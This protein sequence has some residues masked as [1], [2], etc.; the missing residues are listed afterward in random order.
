VKKL[1][2]YAQ[3][4]V[5]H[6]WLIDPRLN[7]LEVLRLESGRW[8]VAGNYGANDI[9]HAEPFDAIDLNLATLW[10]PS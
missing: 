8:V 5:A 3:H 4:C 2:I 10:L 6:V 7:T 1:P 9:V